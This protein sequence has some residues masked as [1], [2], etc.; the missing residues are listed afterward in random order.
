M[1]DLAGG[2][3]AAQ[4]LLTA[5]AV[6]GATLG[7]HPGADGAIEGSPPTP[8]DV[9]PRFRFPARSLVAL[10]LAAIGGVVCQLFQLPAA[11]LAGSAI[12]VAGASIAGVPTGLP[13]WLRGVTFVVLGV[14]MGASVTPETVRRIGEWP[15]SLAVL[16]VT[17]VAVTLTVMLFLRRRHGWDRDSALLAALPGALSYVVAAA[18]QRDAD[19]RKVVTSQS[20]RL[21]FLVA[22]LPIVIGHGE[23]GARA[24]AP[25]VDLVELAVMLA[26]GA[27]VG[28]LADRIRVPAGLL[29]GAFGASAL[30]HGSG[31]VHAVLPPWLAIPAF[32]VLGAFVGTR[33]SGA[34]VGSLVTL[35]WSSVGAFFIGAGVAMAGALVTVWATGQPLGDALL[36]VAP[37][38][39]EAMTGLAYLL[40]ADPAF[41]AVHQLVRFIAI[42]VSL[43]LVLRL[44]GPP[45]RGR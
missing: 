36:A 20:I 21:M 22:V 13:G 24:A 43:P 23:G 32:V 34:D 38:G 1:A 14:S 37:G 26:V 4:G 33:F 11:W 35:A 7:D 28:L 15:V 10:G 40:N 45:S 3:A 42:A 17:V 9:L 29:A 18:Q 12:L 30:L 31:L 19:I 2:A 5:A 6:A 44:A 8:A 27:A 39:I 25:V 16:L 41:V